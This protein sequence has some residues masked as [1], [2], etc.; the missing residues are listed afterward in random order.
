[1]CVKCD[2][3]QYV[4]E[5]RK[6]CIK[7]SNGDGPNANKTGCEK[8]PIEYMQLNTAFT[9]VPLVFSSFGLLL[10]A[11][12]IG[13]FIR[14]SET[15]I[16]KA[17]G[18][19]LCYVLLSGIMSCYL[20]TF[21]LGT[22]NSNIKIQLFNN[23]FKS[24]SFHVVLKPTLVSCLLLRFGVSLSLTICLSALFTKTFRLSRIFNK[25][26]RSSLKA[27]CVSPNSQLVIC[28]SIISVQIVGLIL[29]VLIS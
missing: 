6:F 5:D 14:Y 4:S 16:I 10:T 27:S 13:V 17:S 18:R 3:T 11:F 29:W 26:V 25:S 8:L 24:H 20:I 21:P 1:M 15:P 22:N 9:L 19:E 7:C 12:T 28:F 2:D 23:S